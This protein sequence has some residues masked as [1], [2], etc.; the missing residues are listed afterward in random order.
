LF[1]TE[2]HDA[3]SSL[4]ERL[5]RHRDLGPHL[6][7]G[8]PP[9]EAAVLDVFRVGPAAGRKGAVGPDAYSTP[10][11]VQTLT[12]AGVAVDLPDAPMPPAQSAREIEAAERDREWGAL[13]IALV[14]QH[15]EKALDEA[16]V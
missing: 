12:L 2:E 11:L 7:S 10:A 6:R 14:E 1:T 15:A 5:R 8:L 4:V 13:Y 3:L 16:T 9:A